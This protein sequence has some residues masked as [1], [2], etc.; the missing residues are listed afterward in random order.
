MTCY[1]SIVMQGPACLQNMSF[2][3]S[4]FFFL[5]QLRNAYAQAVPYICFVPCVL[6]F[7]FLTLSGMSQLDFAIVAFPIFVLIVVLYQVDLNQWPYKMCLFDFD[8]QFLI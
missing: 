2:F 3:F 6:C 7:F 5:S 8:T 1:A 4:L